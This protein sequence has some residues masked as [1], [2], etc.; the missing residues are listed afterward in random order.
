MRLTRYRGRHLV[1][2]PSPVSQLATP[3]AVGA[4]TAVLA[5]SPAAASGYRVQSGD[6]LSDIAARTGTSVERLVE[7]NS[8]SD[9]D[10][11]IA[12]ETLRLAGGAARSAPVV[13]AVVAG[14]NL[15]GIAA[16]YGVTIDALAQANDIVDVNFIVAGERLRIPSGGN[17][18]GSGAA[19][20]A[21]QSADNLPE[22]APS[23]VEGLLESAAA[24][25]GLPADL[26]K[27]VAYQ[28]SGWQQ[29]VVSSA[30]A[31]GVMQVMPDTAD[32]VN[33]VLGAGDLDERDAAGNVTLGTTY[34]DHLVEQMPSENKALAAYY[35]GPGNVGRK[36][37][38]IQRAYVR[39]VQALRDRF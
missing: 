3:A 30:G 19:A 21:G 12:G 25:R 11:I 39:S 16:R 7:L 28:E 5:A 24:A 34:L 13:H 8:L 33:E 2:R 27:A 35:T 22:A 38:K 23:T 10:R 17:H 29:D 6:T 20:S 1:P 14:E 4:A 18:G 31:I 37:S 36:L 26:V 9:P 32:Y 15:A